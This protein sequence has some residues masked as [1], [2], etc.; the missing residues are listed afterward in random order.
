ML[1][2]VSRF[3][4]G[5]PVRPENGVFVDRGAN[6]RLVRVVRRF[7]AAHGDFADALLET[8]VIGRVGG[9]TALG[10]QSLAPGR[11]QA[12][13]ASAGPR[14]VARVRTVDGEIEVMPDTAAVMQMQQRAAN[15]FD[16]E[17]FMRELRLGIYAPT[18]RREEER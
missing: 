2:V 7:P 13:V 17:A 6:Q 1:S 4:A 8:G 5:V 16:L 14:G 10:V 15:Y 12:V 9:L 3:Q 18:A 11:S